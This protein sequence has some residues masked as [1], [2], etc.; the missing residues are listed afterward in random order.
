MTY[1][2]LYILIVSL[3]PCCYKRAELF[4]EPDNPQLLTRC[5]VWYGAAARTEWYRRGGA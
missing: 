5:A 1:Y 3:T 2:I 4:T